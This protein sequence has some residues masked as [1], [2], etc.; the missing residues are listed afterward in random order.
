METDMQRFGRRVLWQISDL[1]A[2]RL[3]NELDRRQVGWQMG[4][5]A[6]GHNGR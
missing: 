2:R 5:L 4:R 1:Q 3:E 6:D